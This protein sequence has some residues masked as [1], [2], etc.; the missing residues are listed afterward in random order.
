MHNSSVPSLKSSLFT[1]SRFGALDRLLERMT[2]ANLVG[3][4][5]S[6]FIL[7][8]LLVLPLSLSI[9]LLL[10]LVVIIWTLLRPQIALYL[11]PIAVPWGSLDALNLG[12]ISVSSAD[13]LVLLLATSWLLSFPL[14]P[15]VAGKQVGPLD[16]EAFN[17]PR[18]LV[19]AMVAF[20]FAMLL[21]LTA[22]SAF[23]LSFKEISK[24]LEF[25]VIVLLGTQYLRTRRQIWLLVVI[26]CFAA[27]SQALLG[28]MQAY[29][30]LGPE[31]FI[32]DEARGLRIYGTFDQPNPFAGFINMTLTI[33]IA[34]CLLGRNLILRI[35]AG[36][37]ALLL[38]V[39]L[40]L[41]QS[42]G[43]ELALV[44]ALLFIVATGMPR[45]RPLIGV[46][47]IVALVGVGAYFAGLF[48]ERLTM[49]IFQKLG[50]AGISLA[51]PNDN[52]YATAE[53]LAHWI[54]GLNMF[55]DHPLFG[56]G[57]GNYPAVYAHY[58]VTV[59]ALPLGHA[60]NY[61]INIA[62]E[63][64]V[65]GLATYIFFL[66]AVFLAGSRT[67]RTIHQ[68]LRDLQRQRAQ[69]SRERT[70][71]EH[72]HLVTCLQKLTDERALTIGLLA[73][74]VSICAHNIVDNLYVHSMTNLFALLLAI[75][76]RLRGVMPIVGSN[77]GRFDY[78]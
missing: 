29:Y 71:S 73:A 76:I 35:L 39:A 59:F 22:A 55:L 65:L 42:R 40:Y 41:S 27:L 74:L 2:L 45:L 17:T 56:V 46:G 47:A 28:Y 51:V 67:L 75:L 49:P 70:G 33:V 60:H 58:F 15:F 53:R 9:R 26:I 37:T 64:G 77:G 69:R 12:G 57:I 4:F 16:R 13:I 54:S 78:R 50:L 52:D 24:W 7:F 43:G 62:A 1:V 21:S 72:H 6:I 10:Y 5:G 68:Q 44:I 32:R 11:M 19:L 23:S 34:L 3:L 61:Y 31:S 36:V 14:R 18:Y 8:C 48:P 25:L 38:V 66:W 63:T 20:L 30:N